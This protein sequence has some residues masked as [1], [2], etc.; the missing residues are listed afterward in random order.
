MKLVEQAIFTSAETDRGAEYQVVSRSPGVCD[1]DAREL[2]VWEPSRDALLD[3]GPE[4]ESWNFHPLPSGAF[5]VSH[6]LPAGRE[7]TGG[8]RVSSHCLIV[9]PEILERFANNPFALIEAATEQ[10]VWRG[11]ADSSLTLDAIPI[12]GGAKPTDPMLLRDLARNPGP[13]RMAA[14]IQRSCNAVCLGLGGVVRPAPLI[15]GLFQCLPMECRLEFSFSTGLRFSPWR[16]FRVVALSDDPAERLWVST[17]PN[18]TVL[19]LGKGAMTDVAPLDGWALLIER[20]LTP[21]HVEFLAERI[22]A[23]R[24]GL[25]LDDLPALGLQLLEEL[26]NQGLDDN[27]PA[28]TLAA[29]MAQLAHAPHQRFE[30]DSRSASTQHR[31]APG[32]EHTGLHSPEVLERLE[33][34]DDLVYEA[35][36]GKSESLGQLR[37]AWPK[38]LEELGGPLL[39]ESREQYLRYA[40]S[41]WTECAQGGT[42]RDPIRAIQA[43]DVLC[44]LFDES[45]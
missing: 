7:Q 6:S 1:V 21:E 14:L 37:E 31:T 45:M 5:C 36:S 23:R 10:Q 24:S 15:A 18:V 38:V 2:A 44:L 22:S 8:R 34:L 40:L 13:Q 41:I 3:S 39:A 33:D 20:A 28:K 32:I 16:P 9:P 27:R 43:L 35:I 42:I 11:D 4:A 26:D 25:N 17:Y 29:A 12:P 30:K 19:E